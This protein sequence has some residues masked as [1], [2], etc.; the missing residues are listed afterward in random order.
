MGALGIIVGLIAFACLAPSFAGRMLL[1]VLLIFLNLAV[2]G[3][4]TSL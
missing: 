4:L 2:V 1:V 3:M